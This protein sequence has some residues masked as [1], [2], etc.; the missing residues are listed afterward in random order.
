[1]PACGSYEN[2]CPRLR[3]ALKA[4]G[5]NDTYHGFLHSLLNNQL[6]S[7]WG[8]IKDSLLLEISASLDFSRR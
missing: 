7:G 1:M 4:L 3:K 2:A 8:S 5:Y 6:I